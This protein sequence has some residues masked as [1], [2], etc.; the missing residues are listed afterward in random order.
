MPASKFQY[1]LPWLILFFPLF[2]AIVTA[3]F[4]QHNR[5]L[6][7][8]LS[9]GAVTAGFILSIVFIAWAG[10]SPEKADVAITWLSVGDFRVDLGLRLDP[11]SLLMMLMVTG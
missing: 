5:K 8:T 4:T 1:L 11:L 6:S 10:W 7:A 2:A 3:L 9:I